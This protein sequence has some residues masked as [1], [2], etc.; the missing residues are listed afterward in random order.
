MTA[1][2]RDIFSQNNLHV[3]IN[4][5]NLQMLVLRK[6]VLTH[7]MDDVC[8]RSPISKFKG[9]KIERRYMF[10]KVSSKTCTQ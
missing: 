2:N 1:N 7:Q 8:L 6:I 4:N 10:A 5:K 3:A 9:S